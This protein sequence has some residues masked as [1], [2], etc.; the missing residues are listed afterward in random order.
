MGVAQTQETVFTDYARSLI[1][2]KARQLVRTPGFNNSDQHDLEQDLWLS[3]LSLADRFDPDRASLNT[4]VD[5]IVSMAVR[6]ILRD[7]RRLKRAPGLLAQSL[8]HSTVIS[9]GE[10]VPLRSGVSPTDLS[11]RTGGSPEERSARQEDAE[12]LRFAMDAM[13]RRLRNVCRRMMAGN[14]SSV[15][16]DLKTSRRQIHNAM[17]EARPY[18][19]RAGFGNS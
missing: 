5:R 11:R 10:S 15:A 14:V 7:R 19:E 9:G 12:A 18:F 17:T 1:R 8:E 13:P 2:V 6:M 16:R 3:L 4:F